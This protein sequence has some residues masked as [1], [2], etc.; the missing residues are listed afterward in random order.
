MNAPIKTLSGKE[1]RRQWCNLRRWAFLSA[2]LLMSSLLLTMIVARRSGGE[3][4]GGNL[5]ATDSNSEKKQEIALPP[6]PRLVDVV[7]DKELYSVSRDKEMRVKVVR[8]RW[9]KRGMRLTSD[10]VAKSFLNWFALSDSDE[11]YQ[12]EAICFRSRDLRS[13]PPRTEDTGEPLELPYTVVF[14]LPKALEDEKGRIHYGRYHVSFYLPSY[15]ESV[16]SA[17][18]YI[19][20]RP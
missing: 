3:A 8:I 4:N 1:P 17:P 13:A 12:I 19:H 14:P 16:E 7:F 15:I 20:V 10:M 18:T 11:D 9:P 2:I 5:S 6:P